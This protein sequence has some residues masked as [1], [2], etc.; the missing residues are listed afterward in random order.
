MALRH[1]L[2]SQIPS[3]KKKFLKYDS[4]KDATISDIFTPEQLKGAL[5]LEA[6]VFSSSIL[7]NDGKGKF[8][9][10]QLP[11]EAQFSSRFRR[12]SLR[13]KCDETWRELSFHRQLLYFEF[14]FSHH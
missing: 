8:E 12:I 3:L 6:F 11:M 7:I 10:K 5:H 4:Y 9:I 2:I 1:D 13:S 14:P